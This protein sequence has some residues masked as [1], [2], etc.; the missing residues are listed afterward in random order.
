MQL[1][2]AIADH[3]HEASTTDEPATSV[4]VSV[5][6]QV[7][8]QEAF[9][10]GLS[11]L[12]SGNLLS[13]LPI[14]RKAYTGTVVFGPQPGTDIEEISVEGGP[15]DADEIMCICLTTAL[16]E[17]GE[18]DWQAY[19]ENFLAGGGGDDVTFTL[20]EIVSCEGVTAVD[21]TALYFDD[22]QD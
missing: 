5:K 16:T 1:S 7:N 13:D 12:S 9:T 15:S 4:T 19:Q 10:I 18:V 21:C 3:D 22:S 2:L 20:G 11:E 8:N 6:P 17:E 14:L